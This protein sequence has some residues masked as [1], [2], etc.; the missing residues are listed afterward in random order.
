L[1]DAL[2]KTPGSPQLL[3]SAHDLAVRANA[4]DRYVHK[5]AQVAESLEASDA[6]LASDL[7]MRLGTM[8]EAELADPE[9][10]ANYFERS[11]GTGR[12]VLRAYRALLRVVPEA[13]APRLGRV[14][15]KFLESPDQDETD[16]TPRVEAL[17]RLASVELA[18]AATRA[19]GARRLEQA[20]E[21]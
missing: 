9:R 13:D 19:D 15:R 7:W 11:L 17:Y 18:D 14:L 6:G 20:L 4:L 10:A 2:G 3:S 8:A 21:R 1:L 16:V 12:R 5:L